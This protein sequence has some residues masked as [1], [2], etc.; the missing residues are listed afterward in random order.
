ML[1][2]GYYSGI[3]YVTFYKLFYFLPLVFLPDTVMYVVIFV[4]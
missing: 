1:N 3:M 2:D 4:D